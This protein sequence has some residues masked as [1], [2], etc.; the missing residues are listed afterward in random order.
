MSSS[1]ISWAIC[2][3]AP[4]S[5]QT[6]TPAS[7]HSVFYRPDALPAAQQTPSKHWRQIADNVSENAAR[8][9]S[10]CVVSSKICPGRVSFPNPHTN[11][12]EILAEMRHTRDR[13]GATEAATTFISLSGVIVRRAKHDGHQWCCCPQQ[14]PDQ[15]DASCCCC[16]CLCCWCDY[17]NT[18]PA[19]LMLPTAFVWRPR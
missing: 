1:V 4:C 8:R 13:C 9:A 15:S 10:F 16:C 17:A 12:D 19:Q 3:F 14:L 5:R 18:Q 7:H 2:K 6:T 11:R